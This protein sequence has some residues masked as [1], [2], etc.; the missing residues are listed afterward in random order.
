MRKLWK[1]SL[2]ESEF[3]SV[4]ASPDRLAALKLTSLMDSPQKEAFDRITRLA[5][6]ALSAPVALISLV[7]GERQFFKSA[8][9]LSGPVATER[10]TPLSHSF[11]QFVVQSGQ[12]LIVSDASQHPLFRDNPAVDELGVRSYLGVPLASSDGHIIGACAAIDS[13]VREWSDEEISALQDAAAMTMQLIQQADRIEN[14]QTRQEAA[15]STTE[16]LQLILNSTAEGIYGVDRKGRCTFCNRRCVELLGFDSPDD[17]IGREMHGLIHHTRSDGEAYPLEEC[18]IYRAYRQ[19]QKVHVDSEVFWRADGSSFD[20]EYSSYPK[21]RGGKV[22]GAVV[23]FSDITERRKA[24]KELLSAKQEAEAANRQKSRFLANVSH[25]IRTPMNA[26]LGFSELLEGEVDS[27]KAK[28]HLQIIRSSGQSLINLINDILDLTK[29]ES[30]KMKLCEESVTVRELVESVRVLFSQQG[31]EK[32]LDLRSNVDTDVPDCLVLDALRIRQILFNLLGNALKFTQAGFISLH[33]SCEKEPLNE[34]CVTLIIEVKDTGCGIPKLEQ[35]RIFQP[36]QQAGDSRMLE[37][38]GTGLGLSIVKRLVNL[39]KGRIE[40]DSSVGVGTT[41]TISLPKINVSANL[42][43]AGGSQ[44]PELDLNKIAPSKVLVADDNEFNRDLISGYFEDTHHEL[45]IARTGREAVE[46]TRKE[47]PDIVLMDIRMPDMDGK[48]AREEIKGDAALKHIPVLAV[49]ASSL[50]Q[51]S[52]QLKLIF[53]GYVRKPFSRAEL[54]EAMASVLPLAGE[55]LVSDA[56]TN[57]DDSMIDCPPE[58]M[59]EAWVAAVKTV[60]D[61]LNSEW[62]NLRQTMSMTEIG[63]FAD[64]LKELGNE[65]KCQPLLSYGEVLQEAVENFDLSQIESALGN[66]PE[67]LEKID[68]LAGVQ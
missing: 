22:R 64:R 52:N 40:V 33:I 55:T 30:G 38:Q 68:G 50:M 45:L 17:L 57:Q 9:G 48:K 43:D 58:E 13:K 67:L 63:I 42:V 59:K 46:K 8:C 37:E 36:F 26:I 10:G 6:L 16:R 2:M 39:M 56:V 1:T 49:T 32:N 28:S 35:R 44:T 21:I 61:A 3:D 24:E 53:D 23:T 15:S 62:K 20:V 54:V 31:A 66:V 12:N 34:R 41:L 60:R 11:C 47:V 18:Q 4:L 51:Q 65:A 7:D 5:S 25:E 14:E 27:P 29:I 19:G